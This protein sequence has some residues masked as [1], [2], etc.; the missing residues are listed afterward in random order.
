MHSEDS[1]FAQVTLARFQRLEETDSS[2]SLSLKIFRL[3]QKSD[4]RFR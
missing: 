1:L 2:L 3:A 4:W